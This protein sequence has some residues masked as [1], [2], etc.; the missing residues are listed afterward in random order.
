MGNDRSQPPQSEQCL[1]GKAIWCGCTEQ[2]S[3]RSRKGSFIGI[4][5]GLASALSALELQLK[6]QCS[7]FDAPQARKTGPEEDF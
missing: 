2:R 5:T 1:S 4:E 7:L 3:R 6:G